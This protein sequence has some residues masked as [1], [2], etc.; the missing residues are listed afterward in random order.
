MKNIFKNEVLTIAKKAIDIIL[1][2]Q[3]SDNCQYYSF[4]DIVSSDRIFKENVP[5]VKFLGSGACRSALKYKEIVIK[6]PNDQSNNKSINEEYK[7][8][9][10]NKNNM[11]RYFMNPIL[12][13]G[14]H[15]NICFSVSPYIPKRNK[16]IKRIRGFSKI[17][18]KL[19]FFD[20][21]DDNIGILNNNMPIMI[22]FDCEAKWRESLPFPKIVEETPSF[23]KAFVDHVN[24]YKSL[25]KI[26]S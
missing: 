8:F 3:N 19:P 10:N 14:R 12:I 26:F 21:H 9:K 7:Y 1:I 11:T 4:D 16:K 18:S 2:R 5:E 20:N 15:K 23:R 24:Y 17:V 6:I 22:D 13:C 25:E